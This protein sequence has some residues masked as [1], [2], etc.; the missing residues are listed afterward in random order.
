VITEYFETFARTLPPEDQGRAR[1][2]IEAGHERYTG[3]MLFKE[4]R[5]REALP[6]LWRAVR[7]CPR[8]IVSPLTGPQ[9]VAMILKSIAGAVVGRRGTAAIRR[10]SAVVRRLARR[11][12]GA[13]DNIATVEGSARLSD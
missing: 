2:A 12:T 3:L 10:F 11:S 8:S 5:C 13:G 6:H 9:S 4:G 1:R 7:T